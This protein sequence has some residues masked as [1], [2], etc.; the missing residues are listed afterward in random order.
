M[1]SEREAKVLAALEGLGL[2]YSKR[3]HPPAATVEEAV[4]HWRDLPGALCKNLFLRNKKGNHHYLVVAEHRRAVDLR[5]LAKALPDDR[6]SFASDER[7]ARH[8]GVEPGAVGPFGLIN[9]EA[10]SVVVLIDEELR[11]AP[12]LSFHPNVNT[13][14]V[15]LSG[16]DFQAFLAWRGNPVRFIRL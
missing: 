4:L 3:D 2:P 9:D 13:A 15:T 11:S 10:R 7:L 12:F 14:T 6:L 16:R 8:L 1:I 5:A